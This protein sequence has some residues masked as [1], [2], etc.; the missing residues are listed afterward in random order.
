MANRIQDWDELYPG[1]FFKAGIIGDTKPVLTISDVQM[2]PLETD[3]GTK[4]KGILSFKGEKLQLP[5]NK[6]NGICLREMFG[7]VPYKWA[8][9]SFAIF[10]SEWAGEPC[11]RI[12]GSPELTEDIKVT[13]QLPKKKP[14]NMVMH[15]MGG[16]PLAAVPTPATEK[17]PQSEGCAKLLKLM[18]TCGTLDELTDVEA[19]LAMQTFSDSE[20]AL[21]LKA[22]AR[23]KGQLS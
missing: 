23:R 6:T 13:I 4:D 2:E 5:L 3:K 14:L 15:A 22:L 20:S 11:I 1:R 19:D 9:H 21:L 18:G 12:W 17:A 8:G 16:K 10:Q 7:R